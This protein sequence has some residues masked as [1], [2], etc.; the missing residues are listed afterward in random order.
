MAL[1]MD[2]SRLNIITYGAIKT[3]GTLIVSFDG[4]RPLR[5]EGPVPT[6]FPKHDSKPK[7]LVLFQELKLVTAWVKVSSGSVGLPLL[8]KIGYSKT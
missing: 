1:V 5:L 2:I 8:H 7:F 6:P 3:K 4:L